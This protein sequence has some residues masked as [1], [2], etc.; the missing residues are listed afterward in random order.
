[1]LTRRDSQQSTAKLDRLLLILLIPGLIAALIVGM[2]R[3]KLESKS[4]QIELT[5]DYQELQNL[6][7]SSGTSIPDLLKQFKGAGVTGIAISEDLL[8]DFVSTGQAKYTTMAS[9]DGPLN[10]ITIPDMA[11]RNRVLRALNARLPQHFIMNGDVQ[12]N[13]RWTWSAAISDKLVVRAATNTLSLI[14]LGPSPVAVNLVKQAGLDVVT[15]LQN[16]PALTKKAVD[17]AIADMKAAGITRLVSAGEE[18]FGYRGLIDY[19]ANKIKDSGLVFGSI[20]FSK[21]RGDARMSKKLDSQFIRV[22]SVSVAE[23]GTMAPSSIIERFVRAVKERDIKLCYLRLPETSG[24]NPRQ[25]SI[26]FVS[27]I[28]KQMQQ[29]GYQMGVAEPFGSTSRPLPL[30]ILMALTIT[31]G[32]VLLLTSLFSVSSRIKY[33][34]LVLGFM[35]A[36]GLSMFETGRQLL[37]LKAA[38]IFPTLGVMALAGPYF[39]RDTDEKSP[40]MK[41]AVMFIGISLFSLCGALIVIGLLSD[42]SYMVKVNQFMGIKAAHLL[43]LMLVMFFMV[44]GLPIMGKPFAQVKDEAIANI[45]KVVNHPLFV[46]HA[47]AVLVALVIIGLAVMRTGNDGGVGVSGV[48]LKFR[49]ILDKLMVVRPRTKEFLIGHPALFIGLAMLLTRRRAWGLPLVAFGVLGQVSLLNTFCHIHTPLAVSILRA[50]NGIILGLL[51]GMAAWL[52]L[53]RPK[54]DRSNK[55]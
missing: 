30:L 27:T 31:A 6:S 3:Y 22:H 49:A 4:R 5:L 41:A 44:A 21:Q 1:M 43:P 17:A 51:I 47:I 26:D 53:A 14:G 36:A 8:G 55:T 16:H 38:L 50:G 12:T 54:R 52:I 9:S 32:G 20:E 15:R 48:E 23:M 11:L 13:G 29:S 42:R 24:E 25:D 2:G 28:S 19:T 40:A 7:V 39:G 10:M 18:V 34:L 46:W 33:G 35:L 45:R 37:A